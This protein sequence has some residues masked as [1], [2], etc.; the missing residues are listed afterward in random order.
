M[1]KEAT[2]RSRIDSELKEQSE[3]ILA[4]QGFTMSQAIT[5]MLRQVVIQG[6]LPFP[7]EG[8]LKLN[9]RAQAICD[10][11]DRGEVVVTQHANSQELFKSLGIP[12][13]ADAGE[14]LQKQA[15]IDAMIAEKWPNMEPAQARALGTALG[16]GW[17]VLDIGGA[18]EVNIARGEGPATELWYVRLDGIYRPA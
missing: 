4:E 9:P 17:R 8:S 15:A 14:K 13:R 16:L 1:P 10:A 3:R 12:E 7:I 11:H 6:R 5:M 18:G 2:V